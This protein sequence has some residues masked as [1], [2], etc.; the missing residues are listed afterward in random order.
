M[1]AF[2]LLVHM[3]LSV[4][5]DCTL[6]MQIDLILKKNFFNLANPSSVCYIKSAVCPLSTTFGCLRK[7]LEFETD[8][9]LELFQ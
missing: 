2:M 3:V 7:D 1:L 8:I 9:H 6:I 5:W 4:T